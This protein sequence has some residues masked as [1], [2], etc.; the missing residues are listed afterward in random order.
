MSLGLASYLVG[1]GSRLV[2]EI[3]PINETHS[4]QSRPAP[5]NRAGPAG[6]RGGDAAGEKE[7]GRA[8]KAAPG[9][10]VELSVEIEKLLVFEVLVALVGLLIGDGFGNEDLLADDQFVLVD[11]QVLLLLVHLE[12]N[13]ARHGPIVRVDEGQI[14]A[15]AW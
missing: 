3:L 7:A 2:T 4:R 5:P 11:D 6:T 14:V 15:L 10:S 9:V 13:A 12:L 8:K 1:F